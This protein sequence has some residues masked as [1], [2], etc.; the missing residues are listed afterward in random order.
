MGGD[1]IVQ[2]VQRI[3]YIQR[4]KLKKIKLYIKPNSSHKL[5]I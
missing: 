3:L 5:R 2:I 4:N 1:L